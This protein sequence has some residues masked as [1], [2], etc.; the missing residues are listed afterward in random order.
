MAQSDRDQETHLECLVAA[1]LTT[2]VVDSTGSTPGWVVRRYAETLQEL[3][4]KGGPV[5]PMA[6]LP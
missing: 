4:A 6:A 5:N 1:I 2:A 3:R